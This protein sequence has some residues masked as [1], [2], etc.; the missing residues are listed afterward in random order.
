MSKVEKLLQC[1]DCK[2][3]L[4]ELCEALDYND[5]EREIA[6]EVL[7]WLEMGKLKKKSILIDT[8]KVDGFPDA[9]KPSVMGDTQTLPYELYDIKC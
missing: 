9:T 1:N 2:A 3:K 7:L 5:A 6:A 4:D 8:P